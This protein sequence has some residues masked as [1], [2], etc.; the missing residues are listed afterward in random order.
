MKKN[1]L[2]I[3]EKNIENLKRGEMFMWEREKGRRRLREERFVWERNKYKDRERKTRW[4]ER[5]WDRD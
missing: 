5:E 3:K 2:Y 1:P 4:R